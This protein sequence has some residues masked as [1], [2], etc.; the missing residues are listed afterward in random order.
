MQVDQIYQSYALHMCC[1]LYI[2]L[3]L[4]NTFKNSIT[5]RAGEKVMQLKALTAYPKDPGLISSTYWC[6]TDHTSQPS[7]APV[8]GI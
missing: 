6:S 7:V 8:P 2:K 5:L 4:S 1:S 3:Y